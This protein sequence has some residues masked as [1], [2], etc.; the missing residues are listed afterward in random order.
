MKRYRRAC[1]PHV[2][3]QL[4]ASTI[5]GATRPGIGLFLIGR[6]IQSHPIKPAL[7][8]LLLS[9]TSVVFVPRKPHSQAN[10]PPLLKMFSKLAIFATLALPVFAAAT[11]ASVV[12]RNGGGS[13]GSSGS[14]GSGSSGSGSATTACCSSTE[15][16]CPSLTPIYL[17]S[18]VH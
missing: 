4:L 18:A 11:P 10:Q 13:S 1:V 14:S 6:D 3:E 15:P 7:T 8:A 9:S 16:V 12:A 2:V 17:Y 5:N